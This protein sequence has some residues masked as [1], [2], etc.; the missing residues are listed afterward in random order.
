MI[1]ILRSGINSADEIFDRSIPTDDVSEVVRGIIEDVRVNGDRALLAYC[2]K[3]DKAKLDTLE[4][5]E[6]EIAAAF[7][8]VEPEFI[9]T[10]RLAAENIR[11]FHSHQKRS[12]FVISE[13]AGVITGQKITPI[14][15]VGLY[16]PGGT[17]A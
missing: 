2:E 17:A 13:Q 6:E 1:R 5:S 14:E 15:K 3:F 10:L 9:E 4:V 16:V 12:S 8:A 11:A 7:E